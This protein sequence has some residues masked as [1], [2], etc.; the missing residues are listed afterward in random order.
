[1]PQR[2]RTLVEDD[3]TVADAERLVLSCRAALK[4]PRTR[5]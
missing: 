1:V 4:G 3:W 2:R 5:G